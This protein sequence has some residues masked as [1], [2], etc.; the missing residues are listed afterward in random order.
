MYF[1]QSRLIKAIV[2]FFIYSN[3]LIYSCVELLIFQDNKKDEVARP[4]L[5]VL[6]SNISCFLNEINY[7]VLNLS[8]LE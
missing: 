2:F 4:H 5:F 3:I 7:S 6:T 1:I 8:A